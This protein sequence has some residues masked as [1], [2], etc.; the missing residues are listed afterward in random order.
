MTDRQKLDLIREL[1]YDYYE[2]SADVDG[3]QR[4]AAA[5]ISAVDEG[6]AGITDL[7]VRIAK[8]DLDPQQLSAQLS[9]IVDNLQKIRLAQEKTQSLLDQLLEMVQKVLDW[10]YGL[11]GTKI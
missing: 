4:S 1:I 6:L 5:L 8:L 3:N 2:Y 7:G 9:G 11:F 10:F